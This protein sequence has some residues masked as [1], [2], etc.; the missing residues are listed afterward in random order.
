M[1]RPAPL[2]LLCALGL[3]PTVPC[4]AEES[5]PL[6]PPVPWSR[7][8]PENT[9]ADWPD[10]GRT[11]TIA[12]LPGTDLKAMVPSTEPESAEP[13]RVPMPEPL[14]DE[15]FLPYTPG[16]LTLQRGDVVQISVYGHRDTVASDVPIAPDG[17]LYYMFLPGIPATDRTP[18]EVAREIEENIRHLFNNPKVSVLPQTFSAN[19]Y[20]II[21]TVMHPG[22]YPLERPLT[23]RQAVAAAKGIA[24]GKYKGTTIE[25]AD[26]SNSYLLRDH[27]KL[28]VD[29]ARLFKE[30]DGSQDVYIRP[31]D[32]IYVASGVG[33][34][35]FVMGSV[36]D[37]RSQAYTEGMTLVQLL[38]GQSDNTGGWTQ[39]AD[40]NKVILLR[41]H[42]EDPHLIR[43]NL[44]KILQGKETDVPVLPGDIVYVPQ[45]S[46]L[47]TRTLAKD[48]TAQF[49][50]TFASELGAD[51]A[52]KY[53]FNETN[54]NNK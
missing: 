22:H 31:G 32:V 37:E 17:K 49:I 45:K 48:I 41:G 42:L 4:R 52:E 29:F 54:T 47:W 7:I 2:I 40:L 11:Q 19:R 3:I 23:L 13:E 39:E 25:I 10:G 44:K 6:V 24:Q 53:I 43:V 50:R 20:S 21:G 8:D 28:P 15:Y 46:F 26:F 5:G 9:A 30:N 16:Q 36:T 51:F 35:V 34:E 33:Q 27:Q 18:E 1:K 12:L 38:S 14:P